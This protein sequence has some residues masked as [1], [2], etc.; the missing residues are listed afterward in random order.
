AATVGGVV[1]LIAGAACLLQSFKKRWRGW[2]PYLFRPFIR[3]VCVAVIVGCGIVLANTNLSAPA[4][5]V[6]ISKIVL[7][8]LTFVFL[9]LVPARWWDPGA[10]AIV[11]AAVP[12]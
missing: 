6:L 3:F 11:P 1:A 10:K 5:A 12:T 4:T 7:C 9:T 8:S 2:W